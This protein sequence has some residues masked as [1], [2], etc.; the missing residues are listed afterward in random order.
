MPH[1][2]PWRINPDRIDS[3]ITRGVVAARYRPPHK[4]YC[5]T[6]AE[7]SSC[8]HCWYVNQEVQSHG[9]KLCV[10]QLG[11][12]LDQTRRLEIPRDVEM[13]QKSRSGENY[14]AQ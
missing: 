9:T 11:Q 12:L 5:P 10:L 3:G 13:T 4:R 1:L 8:L 7:L 2:H 14:Q 6:I